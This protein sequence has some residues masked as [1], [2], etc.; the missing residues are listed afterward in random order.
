[1][2]PIV[3]KK[4]VLNIIIN[5][6]KGNLKQIDYLFNYLLSSAYISYHN[7]GLGGF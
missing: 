4:T 2:F 5:F 7:L 6:D 3:I 1:M